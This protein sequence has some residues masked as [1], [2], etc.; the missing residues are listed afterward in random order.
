MAFTVLITET[1]CGRATFQTRE[2][3]EKFAMEPDYD[4]V[5]WNDTLDNE[6]VIREE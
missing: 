2:E 1:N 3:A 4:L 5:K 6:V